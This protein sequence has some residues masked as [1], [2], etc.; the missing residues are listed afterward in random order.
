ME[1]PGHVAYIALLGLCHA[2]IHDHDTPSP[3]GHPIDFAYS[4]YR[5]EWDVGHNTTRYALPLRC[6]ALLL[7]T[8]SLQDAYRLP[9]GMRRVGY[10]ADKG[11]YYFKD[12]GGTLWEGAE[13]AEF[14]ELKQGA[15][16]YSH[17]IRPES[18]NSVI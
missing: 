16:R 9:G 3:D 6:A 8:W 18:A 2:C 4:F 15:S 1:N 5:L 10:D 17:S 12:T 11:K 14:G 13:G 7:M